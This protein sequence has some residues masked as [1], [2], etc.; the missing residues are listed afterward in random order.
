LHALQIEVRRGLFMDEATRRPH[1]AMA[2][3]Q[4]VIR[5]LLLDLGWFMAERLTPAAASPGWLRTAS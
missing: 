4:E 1:R 5:E 3:L 2:R